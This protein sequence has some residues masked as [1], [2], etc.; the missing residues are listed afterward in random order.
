MSSTSKKREWK[1]KNTC[2][3]VWL[4]RLKGAHFYD[5]TSTGFSNF[6]SSRKTEMKMIHIQT[7]KFETSTTTPVRDIVLPIISI[8]HALPP[9]WKAHKKHNIFFQ[10]FLSN[11]PLVTLL[12]TPQKIKENETQFK[13]KFNLFDYFNLLK[14]VSFQRNQTREFIKKKKKRERERERIR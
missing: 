3:K 11:Q 4:G 10:D 14:F 13:F 5:N 1:S 2:L 7:L 9:Q 6:S 12:L 8:F